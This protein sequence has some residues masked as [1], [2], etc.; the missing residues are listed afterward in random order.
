MEHHPDRH[1]L[2]AG[3]AH[4]AGVVHEALG[5]DDIL[6]LVDGVPHRGRVVGRAAV[7]A[8]VAAD[9]VATKGRAHPPGHVGVRRVEA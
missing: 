5:V 7:G 6:V 3:V 1:H 2:K 8:L 4:D 9:G